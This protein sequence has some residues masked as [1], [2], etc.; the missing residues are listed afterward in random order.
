MTTNEMVE[1]FTNAAADLFAALKA[2]PEI[3]AAMKRPESVRNAMA[4]LIRIT[5]K[6]NEASLASELTR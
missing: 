2:N 3:V 6:A 1:E 5:G 4:R